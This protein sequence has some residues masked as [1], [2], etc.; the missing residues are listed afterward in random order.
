[1]NNKNKQERTLPLLLFV[2]MVMSLLSCSSTKGLTSYQIKAHA[3]INDVVSSKKYALDLEVMSLDT[4]QY[5][6]NKEYF[7]KD[8]PF[9]QRMTEQNN[10]ELEYV[11]SEI[12]TQ[13]NSLKKHNL[14]NTKWQRRLIKFRNKSDKHVKHSYPFFIDDTNIA[15]VL[16]FYP[17]VSN[18]VAKNRVVYTTVVL[19]SF[20][21]YEKNH[22]VGIGEI[23]VSD[24]T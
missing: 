9:T 16:T 12:K 3:F 6:L 11:Y 15:V 5:F 7:K 24:L 1:M 4:L 21:K 17:A 20:Y 22:W 13:V 10:F 19:W 14:Y 23:Q 18:K 2:I 8:A